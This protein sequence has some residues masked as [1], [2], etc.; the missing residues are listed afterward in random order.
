MNYRDIIQKNCAEISPL[1]KYA[2]HYSDILNIQSILLSG[3][4]YSRSVAKKLNLMQNDNASRQVIDMTNDDI[5]K[6]VR[7]YFR[8]LTPTQYHNEGYKHPSVRYDRDTNANVPVPIFLVFDLEKLLNLEKTRFSECSQA[9]FGCPLCSTITEFSQFDFEKIYSID[10]YQYKEFKHAEIIYPEMF[11]IDIC[12]KYIVCRN[13]VDKE[14]LLNLLKENQN[15]YK[16]YKSK[17]IVSKKERTL[18]YKNGLCIEDCLYHNGVLNVVFSES[19]ERRKYAERYLT[20]IE[21]EKLS[22]LDFKVELTWDNGHK[23]FCQNKVDYLKF[24][25]LSIKIPI[26]KDA[27]ELEIKAYLEGNLLCSLKRVLNQV[28]LIS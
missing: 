17:V 24:K 8:P 28:E 3:R 18:F 20:R 16:K 14:S 12:L 26:Y 27:S 1:A 4:L 9:G 13:E 15:V 5:T 6:S 10:P 21:L 19:N 11:D 22:S 23:G 7:F 25:L 2:F